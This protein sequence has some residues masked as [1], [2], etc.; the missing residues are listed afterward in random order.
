MIGKVTAIILLVVSVLYFATPLVISRILN[1]MASEV[2]ESC[3]IQWKKTTIQ[4][5]PIR[6]LI[7]DVSL[8]WGEPLTTEIKSKIRSIQIDPLRR[9]IRIENPTVWVIDG[10]EKTFHSSDPTAENFSVQ[11]RIPKK[12]REIEVM[13]GDF[14]YQRV[15]QKTLNHRSGQIHVHAIHARGISKESKKTVT[16]DATAILE[17]S[18]KINLNL[19]FPDFEN[20]SDV[21]ISL[22]MSSF[23]IQEANVYFNQ[24]EGIKFSGNLIHGSSSIAMRGNR[25]SA[26]VRAQYNGFKLEFNKLEER[27]ALSAAI[28]T[29][30]GR[31][32]FQSDKPDEFGPRP[33]QIAIIHREKEEA[34]P[35][36]VFRGLMEAALLEAAK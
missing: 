33:R 36:F 19:F 16:I 9:K 13:D 11:N 8:H 34:I 15:H 4:L 21:D 26:W 32:K 5:F 24:A 20:P 3:N 10:D 23:P 28:E 30:L 12:I 14:V 2:C 25:L 7:F 6:V 29:L 22:L 18:G 31:F 27:S 17:S 35:A 1:R